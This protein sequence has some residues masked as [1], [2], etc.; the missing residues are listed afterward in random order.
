MSRTAL[1][2]DEHRTALWPVDVTRY[3][4]S[5]ALTPSEQEALGML[6]PQLA[7]KKRIEIGGDLQHALDRLLQPLHDLQAQLGIYQRY[8]TT[9]VQ[10]LLR[11]M[12][13]HATTYWGW[14]EDEWLRLLQSTFAQLQQSY[15]A[16]MYHL[17]RQQ[18]LLLAAT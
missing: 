3:N 4:R 2:T 14:S 13:E 6:V 5:P 10:V 11:A 17:A 7:W 16:K 9:P 18:L 12:Y 15:D 8:C 1:R